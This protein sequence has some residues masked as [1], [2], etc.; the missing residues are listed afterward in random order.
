MLYLQLITPIQHLDTPYNHAAGPEEWGLRTILAQV[1]LREGSLQALTAGRRQRLGCPPGPGRQSGAAAPPGA[2]LSIW[3]SSSV[4]GE[5]RDRENRSE[6]SKII[7]SHA[8]RRYLVVAI[9]IFLAYYRNTGIIRMW[10]M[11]LMNI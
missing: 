11:D 7:L 1:K 8:S 5:R 4:E 9:S 10:P 2:G 6:S 3:Y